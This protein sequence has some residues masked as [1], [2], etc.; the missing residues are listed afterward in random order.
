M[1]KIHQKLTKAV[2]Q[3]KFDGIVELFVRTQTTAGKTTF[4]KFLAFSY[5]T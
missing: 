2:F 5:F 4:H 1:S 3:C